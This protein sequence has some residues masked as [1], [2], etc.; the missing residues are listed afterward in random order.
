MCIVLTTQPRDH[1]GVVQINLILERAFRLSPI[2][3]RQKIENHKYQPREVNY[4]SRAVL[5]LYYS[6]KITFI[7]R[8]ANSISIHCSF[9]SLL[10]CS[11]N[12][13]V[14]SPHHDGHAVSALKPMASSLATASMAKKNK[15]AP[16]PPVD[17]GSHYNTSGGRNFTWA[18]CCCGNTRSGVSTR[19]SGSPKI[20][21]CVYLLC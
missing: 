2:F 20:S 3:A 5:Y 7:G 12:S 4:V 11:L 14:L 9:Q 8:R 1:A 19:R 6:V 10:F 15:E 16:D 13:S 18:L 21:Q 17:G